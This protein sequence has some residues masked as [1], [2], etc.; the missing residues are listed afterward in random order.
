MISISNQM[1][2][3]V[4]IVFFAL[5]FVCEVNACKLEGGYYIEQFKFINITHNQCRC[6]IKHIWGM[7]VIVDSIWHLAA[8]QLL[9]CIMCFSFV[10]RILLLI[11]FQNVRDV[12]WSVIVYV[13]FKEYKQCILVLSVLYYFQVLVC[14]VERRG[15][16]FKKFK[17]PKY[18]MAFDRSLESCNRVP[19]ENIC[20]NYLFCG[21]KF[22]LVNFVANRR[23]FVQLML[24]GQWLQPFPSVRKFR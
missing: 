13:T 9:N 24:I 1:L 2:N 14:V 23:R 17:L 16:Q 4:L 3:N 18:H 22:L 20:H 7:I 11:I 8:F 10:L 12:E 19:F 5:R 6:Y 15:G 21:I